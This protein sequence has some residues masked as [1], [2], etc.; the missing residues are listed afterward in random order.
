[1]REI[2][3]H[4]Y[5]PEI[6]EI[7]CLCNLVKR[8]YCGRFVMD[9]RRSSSLSTSFNTANY[10]RDTAVHKGTRNTC[11]LSPLRIYCIALRVTRNILKFQSVEVLR[12]DPIMI[13]ANIQITISAKFKTN[14]NYTH[15][16]V[17]QFCYMI[18]I[19][20]IIDCLNTSVIS[21]KGILVLDI[22]TNIFEF[23]LRI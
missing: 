8:G 19:R 16:Y 12:W 20:Q 21:V 9:P 13:L 7:T 11:K 15:T 6:D 3:M 10:A 4:C 18:S 22:K 5:Y 2:S 1:M 17:V 14:Q 23:L